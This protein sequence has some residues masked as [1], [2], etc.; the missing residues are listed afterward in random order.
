MATA[1]ETVERVSQSMGASSLSHHS[2]SP[3]YG[4][5]KTWCYLVCLLAMLLTVSPGRIGRPGLCV[6]LLI[7]PLGAVRWLRPP[8]TDAV[9]NHLLW[10]VL[11]LGWAVGELAS[12]GGPA[13]AGCLC[14]SLLFWAVY[15]CRRVYNQCRTRKKS[16]RLCFRRCFMIPAPFLCKTLPLAGTS[17]GGIWLGGAMRPIS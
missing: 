16:S 2:P 10:L 3:Y 9:G 1:G 6:L 13:S 4:R 8:G 14:A 12:R 5:L 15:L 7:A 11:A 17:A